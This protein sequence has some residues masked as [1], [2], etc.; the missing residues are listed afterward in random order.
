MEELY[1]KYQGKTIK[2]DYG[3]NS[4]EFIDFANDMKKSMKINAAKYGVRLITFET[5]YYD[6]YGYFKENE[7]KKV[8]IFFI[9]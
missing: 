5:G 4:K 6:M 9:P 8:C 2:D 3:K 1:R 7:T